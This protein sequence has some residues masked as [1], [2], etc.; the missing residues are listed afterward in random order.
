MTIEFTL[1]TGVKITATI[2]G[3]DSVKFAEQLNNP[4]TLF[5]TVGN[6][7]FS[8]HSLLSWNE[9]VPNN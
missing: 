3:F 5:V 8:K 6:N 2:E 1:N 7:G 9:V 4:Q